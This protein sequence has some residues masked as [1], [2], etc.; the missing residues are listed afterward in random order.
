MCLNRKVLIG[1]AAVALGAFV[2]DPALLGRAFPLLLFAI[3]PLSMLFMMRGMRKMGGMQGTPGNGQSCGMPSS[4]QNTMGMGSGDMGQTGMDM[5]HAGG[6]SPSQATKDEL[7]RL[8]AEVDQLHAERA[9]HT[10]GEVS[11]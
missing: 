9:K 5:E 2:F 7:A 4:S 6:P 11:S 1:F 10:Q 8:R 3:C